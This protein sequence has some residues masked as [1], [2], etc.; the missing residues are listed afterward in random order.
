MV[1][2]TMFRQYLR[3]VLQLL[4]LCTVGLFLVYLVAISLNAWWLS[5]TQEL[6]GKHLNFPYLSPNVAQ[7]FDKADKY[8]DFPLSEDLALAVSLP[9]TIST[10]RRRCTRSEHHGVTGEVRLCCIL[11][12]Y[13]CSVYHRCGYSGVL[14]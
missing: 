13:E 12:T 5:R 1:A 14:H 11:S 7:R 2:S 9:L 6:L 8:F 3:Y 10:Y 4:L